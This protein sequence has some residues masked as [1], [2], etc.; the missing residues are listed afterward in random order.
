MV[1][2]KALLSTLILGFSITPSLALA[3]PSPS[4]NEVQMV[5]HVVNDFYKSLNNNDSQLYLQSIAD[6]SSPANKYAAEHLENI[7]VNFTIVDVKKVSTSKYE[8]DILK[9][10]NGEQYPVIPY[11]VVLENGVWKYDPSAIV[12][13]PKVTMK[14]LAKANS[15]PIIYNAPI[16]SQN[17]NF[18]VGKVDAGN[19]GLDSSFAPM[20]FLTYN[21]SNYSTDI[22][23]PGAIR[24]ESMPGEN[25]YPNDTY[26]FVAAEIYEKDSNGDLVW[27]NSAILSAF[28][29]QNY[30]FSG[31]YGY[32]KIWCG[33]YNYGTPGK[34]NVVW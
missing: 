28:D 5:K 1:T 8:V 15:T 26:N 32:H 24:V 6:S 16:I 4:S 3:D 33:N 9:N 30:T 34:Y 25:D 29:N 27:L 13:Y 23:V 2:K 11:D 17:E 21:F 22:Y 14:S 31:Y 12:I 19:S 18:A 10:Q 7:N 20:S